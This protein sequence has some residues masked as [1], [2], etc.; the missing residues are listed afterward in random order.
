MMCQFGAFNTIFLEPKPRY[1]NS[2]SLFDIMSTA[3][4]AESL[5]QCNLPCIKINRS[6][7]VEPIHFPA[8]NCNCH[9]AF[10]P[11]MARKYL[12]PPTLFCQG[13]DAQRRCKITAV[14]FWQLHQAADSKTNSCLSKALLFFLLYLTNFKKGRRGRKS[15]LPVDLYISKDQLLTAFIRNLCLS[16]SGCSIKWASLK[17]FISYTYLER[18]NLNLIRST[19]GLEGKHTDMKQKWKT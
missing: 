16:G 3:R 12:L 6:E 13:A 10:Y 15:L 1:K 7:M 2:S 18:S 5:A 9:L 17:I 14:A 4:N 11:S 19:K 8:Q